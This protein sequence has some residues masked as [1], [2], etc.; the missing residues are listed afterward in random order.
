V[1]VAGYWRFEAEGFLQDEEWGVNRGVFAGKSA[2]S[3]GHL[4]AVVVG[5]EGADGGL[6]GD[7]GD[8]EGVGGHFL[9]A[10][11]DALAY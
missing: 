8:G 6:V 10:L 4:Y 1:D 5:D 7:G 2:H 9:L 3:G 11:G